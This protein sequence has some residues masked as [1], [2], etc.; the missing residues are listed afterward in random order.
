MS[1]LVSVLEHTGGQEG[2]QD[3]AYGRTGAPQ[4]KDEAT[5]GEH[6]HE[7]I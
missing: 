3:V 4:A 5:S 2:T 7:E 1:H 6:N